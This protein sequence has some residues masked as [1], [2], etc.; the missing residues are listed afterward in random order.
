MIIKKLNERQA[1]WVK[2]LIKYNFVIQYCKEKDNAWAD[3][4]S[5]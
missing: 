2:I 4:L 5:R 1:Q 3:V